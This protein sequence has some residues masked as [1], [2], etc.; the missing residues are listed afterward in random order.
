MKRIT[1]YFAAIALT[2]TLLPSHAQMGGPGASGP[3][4]ADVTEKFFGEHT[5]FSASVE[6]EAQPPNAPERLTMPGKMAVLDKKSRFEMDLSQAKG[7][8]LPPGAAEQMK[9]M[10]MDKT[11]IISRPDKKMSYL[12]YPGLTAYA[13]MPTKDKAA[14][15]SKDKELKVTT[16]E[17]GK[18]KFD[19]HD[20]VK[21][22]IVVTDKDGKN[23]EAT[24]W[25]ATDL[26]K[27]PIKLET[28]QQGNAVVMKFKDVK[29][30]KPEAGQFEPPTDYKK[31]DSMMA[32][33]QQEMM[34]RMGGGMNT[35]R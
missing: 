21:N 29:F 6:I 4:F 2:A 3:D 12:I 14:T 19:G 35:P 22:K 11:I 20:C 34:K 31:Y 32:L 25:N 30:E 13:E 26:K 10:G 27:F 7:G 18:E 17:L 1:A 23:H 33:M 9:Q 5:A 15:E 16:T 24:V 28:V 8:G